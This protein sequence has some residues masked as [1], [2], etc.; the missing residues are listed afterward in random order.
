MLVSDDKMY[1]W[2]PR[3]DLD[4]IPSVPEADLPQPP[5]T[6]IH[7]GPACSNFA[8]ID[9]YKIDFTNCK[10][11]DYRMIELWHRDN[12]RELPKILC[13]DISVVN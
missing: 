5:H 9:N 10:I 4:Y 12:E 11:I 2:H 7:K 1:R 8:C 13:I 3:F 6:G